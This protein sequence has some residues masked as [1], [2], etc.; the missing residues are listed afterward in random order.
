LHCSVGLGAAK[1][2]TIF[3]KNKQKKRRCF[4]TPSQKKIL[5]HDKTYNIETFTKS[6][7]WFKP[8]ETFTKSFSWFKPIETLVSEFQNLLCHI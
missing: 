6:F 5:I 1:M 2:E 8:I 7:S 3:E 4:T